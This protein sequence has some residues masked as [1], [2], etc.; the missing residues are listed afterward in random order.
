M[1]DG[2]LTAQE[3]FEDYQV[4]RECGLSETHVFGFLKPL[5][6]KLGEHRRL[7][8]VYDNTPVGYDLMN[9]NR[10]IPH[11]ELSIKEKDK[12]DL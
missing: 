7:V 2:C 6:D 10:A 9:I 1:T 4:Y 3:I 5:I 12:N 11:Y 8:R